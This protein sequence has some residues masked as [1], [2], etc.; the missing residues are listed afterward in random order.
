MAVY[1]LEPTRY[2][3]TLGPHPPV[4]HIKPG[5]TVVTTTVDAWGYDARGQ[6]VTDPPNPQ[7]GPF[8]IE[9]AEPGDTLVVH[10]DHL[11][12]NRERGYSRSVVAD[13]IVEPGYVKEIPLGER[14]EWKIDLLAGRIILIQPLT[15]L[16]ALQLPLAPMLGCFGVAPLGGQALSTATSGPYG[17]NMDYRGF[18]AGVTVYFPVFA[19][20]ALLFVG[21]GH[22]FQADGE[23]LGTG[24]ETSFKVQFTVDLLKGKTIFWPRGGELNP[25]LYCG[26]RSSLGSSGSTRHD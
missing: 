17:G 8:Y 14:A 25:Y 19:P 6:Q 10:L 26:K 4:L 3:N 12:P 22:A 24:I 16:G 11:S 20:G 23:I 9:G 7:T 1:Y 18:T 2:Y 5:D 13:H 21:D 15:A